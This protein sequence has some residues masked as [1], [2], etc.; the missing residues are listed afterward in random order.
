MIFHQKVN[1]KISNVKDIF[2]KGGFIMEI[3]IAL[4]GFLILSEV[5][6]IE[7]RLRRQIQIQ[8]KISEQLDII[9][10]QLKRNKQ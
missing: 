1:Q 2:V 9:I 4:F 10:E 3:I 5:I 8:D 7:I 6:Y